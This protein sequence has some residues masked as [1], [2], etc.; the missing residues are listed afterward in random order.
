MNGDGDPAM[1]AGEEAGSA[2]FVAV[3]RRWGHVATAAVL[4]ATG[5]VLL[6]QGMLLDPGSLSLPGPGFVPVALS[7]ALILLAGVIAVRDWQAGDH[8]PAVGLG[9]RDVV[10]VFAAMLAVPPLFEPLGAYPTLG[11]F[12]AVLLVLVARTSVAVAVAAAVLGMV[13]CWGFFGVALALQLPAGA[14]LES[15]GL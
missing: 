13:A 5:L 14:I 4:A 8:G 2:P 3:D 1:P 6:S 11:L 7:L 12:A 15:F 10:I 9:Y